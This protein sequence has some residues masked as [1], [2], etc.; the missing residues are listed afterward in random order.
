MFVLSCHCLW[1]DLLLVSEVLIRWEDLIHGVWRIFQIYVLLQNLTHGL[2]C[3]FKTLQKVIVESLLGVFVKFFVLLEK[4]LLRT[5]MISCAAC[6]SDTTLF[7]AFAGSVG[8]NSL[9]LLNDHLSWIHFI[10]NC[11]KPWDLSFMSWHDFHVIH[12]LFPLLLTQKC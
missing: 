3:L 12:Q 10:N 9:D 5:Q 6:G 1:K 4:R 2:F 11:K 7:V 8:C